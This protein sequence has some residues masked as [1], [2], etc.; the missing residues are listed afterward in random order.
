MKAF[1]ARLA[2]ALALAV[3]AQFAGA[4]EPARSWPIHPIR[5]VVPFPAPDE[6]A[7]GLRREIDTS[8]VNYVLTRFAFGDLSYEESLRSLN[9]FSRQVMPQFAGAPTLA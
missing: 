1:P 8:G 6:V 2:C 3:T 9:L 4:Q 5:L 7:Q